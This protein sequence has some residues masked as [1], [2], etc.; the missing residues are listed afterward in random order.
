MV[1]V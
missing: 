1:T